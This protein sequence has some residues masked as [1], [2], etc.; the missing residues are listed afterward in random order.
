M[1]RVRSLPVHLYAALFVTSLTAVTASAARPTTTTNDQR[2][3]LSDQQPT[4]QRPTT[5]APTSVDKYKN[6]QVLKDLPASELHDSMVFMTVSLG[7][8]CEFCHVKDAGGAWAWE[9]DD[10]RAKQDAREMIRMTAAI[11]AQ[12]FKGQRPS[13]ATAV[14]RAA[15]SRSRFPCSPTSCRSR[16]PVRRLHR[17]PSPL[18]QRQRRQPQGHPPPRLARRG[19]PRTWTRC[20]TSTSRR[21]A[22]VT[23]SRRSGRSS[24]RAA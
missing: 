10:K 4:N 15:A 2:P 9:K 19:P 14:T 21:W 11:N 6:I 12:S 3:G 22:D 7:A 8:T 13:P 17:G 18:R 16:R 5:T 23:R 1:A 24:R 20:W